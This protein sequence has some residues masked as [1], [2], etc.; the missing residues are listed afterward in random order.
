MNRRDFLKSM[1]SV[2][3]G[4][5]TPKLLDTVPEPVD[6]VVIEPTDVYTPT[7]LRGSLIGVISMS[8]ASSV[9]ADVESNGG[10]KE[11]EWGLKKGGES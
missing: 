1:A 9:W 6:V 11:F 10:F 5:S 8:V 4:G 3:V 7:R 2:L